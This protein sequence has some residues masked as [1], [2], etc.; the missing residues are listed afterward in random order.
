[1]SGQ[2]LGLS[3]RED[4]TVQI[5]LHNKYLQKVIESVE[6]A[7]EKY[8][9][10]MDEI[11]E[12]FALKKSVNLEVKLIEELEVEIHDDCKFEHE[13]QGT[14]LQDNQ[15]ST[16]KEL[17]LQQEDQDNQ[18]SID[19][20]STLDQEAQDYPH[21]N[22]QDNPHHNNLASLDTIIHQKVLIKMILQDASNDDQFLYVCHSS[23]SRDEETHLTY[24]KLRKH[25]HID[26]SQILLG[27]IF[28]WSQRSPPKTNILIIHFIF[29]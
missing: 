18:D 3:S 6:N 12:K 14:T 22:D 21:Q 1:V 8:K 11:N 19:N 2:I 27:H 20:D 26:A 25:S 9:V 13:D 28:L 4:E 7:Y 24:S 23:C 29:S 15:D 16:G 5:F 10:A 17:T